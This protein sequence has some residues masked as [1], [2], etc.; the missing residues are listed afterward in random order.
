MKNKHKFPKIGIYKITSPNNKIYIGQS[1]NIQKRYSKYKT[2]QNKSQVKIYNSIT[3]YGWDLHLFEVLEECS[4][5]NLQSRETFWKEYYINTFGW[6][7]MLF[8]NIIDGKGGY[9]SESIKEKMRKPKHSEDFKKNQSE[10]K[11]GKPIHTDEYKKWLSEDRK[12]WDLT[13]MIKKSIEAN[14]IPVLQFDL[15]GNLIKE[16]SSLIEAAISLGKKQSTSIINCCKNRQKTAYGYYW[17]YKPS[18]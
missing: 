13:Y 17:K 3:K 12:K 7:N 9:L 15:E 1:T 8:F 14:V 5:E 16:H 6:N 18:I 11:K 2:N 10:N 4:I